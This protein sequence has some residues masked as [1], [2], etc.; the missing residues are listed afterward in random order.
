MLQERKDCLEQ[1]KQEQLCFNE[2]IGSRITEDCS[3]VSMLKDY[4]IDATKSTDE[5]KCDLDKM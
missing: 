2:Q 3:T 1:I 4:V 5:L